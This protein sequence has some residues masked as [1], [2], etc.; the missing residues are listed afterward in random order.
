MVA[1]HAGQRGISVAQ[2]LE[3]QVQEIWENLCTSRLNNLLG[4]ART[5]PTQRCFTEHLLS[6]M[7]KA[8]SFMQSRSLLHA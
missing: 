4:P 6:Q 3:P 7:R 2:R 5:V 8:L 1:H